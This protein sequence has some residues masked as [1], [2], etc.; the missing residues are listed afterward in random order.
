MRLLKDKSWLLRIVRTLALITVGLVGHFMKL[1]P[2]SFMLLF[3][4]VSTA[5]YCVKELY[6]LHQDKT[7]TINFIGAITLFC[8]ISAEN[9]LESPILSI[10]LLCIAMIAIIA[11]QMRAYV[12]GE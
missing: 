5:I 12:L 9:M 10:V 11:A 7:E 6:Y 8:S 3:L 2:L 4:G 1:S